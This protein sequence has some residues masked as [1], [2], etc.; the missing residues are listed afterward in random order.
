MITCLEITFARPEQASLAGKG[1]IPIAPGCVLPLRN[2]SNRDAA[3][4]FLP[5]FLSRVR[6][7]SD[8]LIHCH[9]AVTILGV[10]IKILQLVG[11]VFQ[12]VQFV[13]VP[14]TISPHE[15]PTRRDQSM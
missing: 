3:E 9:R 5:P 13:Q 4:Y 1:P 2:R 12:I 14:Q 7:T 6:T 15:L 11:I 8:P 10:W